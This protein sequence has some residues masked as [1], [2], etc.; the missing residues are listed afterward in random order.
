MSTCQFL[1]GVYVHSTLTLPAECEKSDKLCS[2][3]SKNLGARS[4]LYFLGEFTATGFQLEAGWQGEIDFTS[5]RSMVMPQFDMVLTYQKEGV[6]QEISFSL[7]GV[8]IIGGNLLHG[9]SIETH[10]KYIWVVM[11]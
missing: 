7:E 1:V 3:L 6:I 2:F 11:F 4:E 5:T 9:Q 8:M 10:G